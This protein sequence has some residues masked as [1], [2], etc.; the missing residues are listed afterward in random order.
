MNRSLD[1]L[2]EQQ[3]L[4]TLFWKPD[5]TTNRNGKA[6]FSFY[7]GYITGKF[8]IIVHGMSGKSVVYGNEEIE[9]K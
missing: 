2:L 3:Y 6:S 1:G 8:R 7:T 9:V 4:S 5:L